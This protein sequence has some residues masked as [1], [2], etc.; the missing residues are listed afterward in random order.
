MNHTTES[1]TALRKHTPIEAFEGIAVWAEAAADALRERESEYVTDG[2]EYDRWRRAAVEAATEMWLRIALV[3]SEGILPSGLN[4]A[5]RLMER[6][7][8][9]PTLDP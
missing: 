5:I 1:L 9:E 2:P 6:L 4:R 7:E 8:V 3:N